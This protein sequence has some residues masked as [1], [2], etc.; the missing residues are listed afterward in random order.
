[1]EWA[2]R[3]RARLVGDRGARLL[4]RLGCQEQRGHR[5]CRGAAEERE[6]RGA[7]AER[8]SIEFLVGIGEGEL[9]TLMQ[10]GTDTVVAAAGSAVED[11][12]S[13]LAAPPLGIVAFDCVACRG[14]IGEDDLFRE[15][16]AVA[17]HLPE[18]A[19]LG[20]LYTYG[21]IAR[22]GGGLGFHNQTMVVLALQ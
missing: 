22:R 10:G 19:T 6:E 7:D 12:V 15:T 11:A 21:E 4:A 8:R 3:D 5:T 2:V 16:G 17:R 18:G 13:Q 20:G 1:M 14:V 9:V